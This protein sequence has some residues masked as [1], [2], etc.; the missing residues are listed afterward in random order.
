MRDFVYIKDVVYANIFA[1]TNFE[2]LKGKYYEVA[3]GEARGFEDVLDLMSIPFSY[4]GESQIPVGYQFY[5]CSNK[6]K[7]MEGWS[8]KWGLEKGISDYKNYLN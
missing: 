4:T 8:P 1:W 5:T 6:T 3:S 7:W 2:K